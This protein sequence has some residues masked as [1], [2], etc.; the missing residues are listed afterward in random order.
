[1]SIFDLILLLNLNVN[2]RVMMEFYVCHPNRKRKRV[3]EISRI[4]AIV[5][6]PFERIN[7]TQQHLKATIETQDLDLG[8]RKT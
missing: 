6:T 8:A 2:L 4:S 1:M 5:V 7:A 3:S